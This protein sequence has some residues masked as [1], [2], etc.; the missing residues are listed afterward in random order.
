MS[1]MTAGWLE[2]WL[3][4]YLA[5]QRGV[6]PEMIDVRERFSRHGLDS[7]GATKLLVDLGAALGRA[8]S[9]TLIWEHPTIEALARSLI[10]GAGAQ[11]AP[12]PARAVR[13][14]AREPV[15]IV[16]L[17]C[18][19][20]KA[21]SA[22]AFW[23]LL[24]DGVDAITE[25][26]PD[27]WDIDALYDADPGAPGKMS[28]RWGGFLD[29]VDRFD[30]GFFGIS[31]REAIQQDP[32]QR[33]M[34]ELSWEALEDA[35]LSP[36]GLMGSRTGVFFGAMWSDYAKVPGGRLDAIVQHTATGQDL[37]IIPAR[38][39]YTLGLEGPSVEVST[40]CSS[41]LVAVHLACQS[42]QSG[43]SSLA[44][45]GGVNLI[46]SP[47][48]TIAMSKFGA[49]SPDGRSRAFDAAANGYVRGEGGGVVV[50]KPLSLALADG[51]PIY[52][53]IRGSAVNND[54]FSN[55]LTAPNPRAQEAVLR[56]AW[57]QAGVA[58]GQGHYVEAHGTG[59]SLGDPIEAK[60]LG[61]VFGVGRPAE[62]PLRLGS[63][64]TNIGH[65]EAAAGVAGLIKA[66]LAIKH[67][68]IPPSLHFQEPNPH[69]P[70]E[71]LRLQVQRSA[72]A[73]PDEER[74]AL[75]GVSAFGFGGTNCH[76]VLEG[77]RSSPVQL[78][79]LSADS[80]DELRAL[81]EEHRVLST[82]PG[83]RA[84]LLELCSTAAARLSHRDHRLAMTVRSHDDVGAH[85]ESF[86]RGRVRLG[87]SFSHAGDLRAKLVFVF[88]G[89][90]SQW[91][92]MGR[93]LLQEEPAFRVELER[94]E[95]AM[96]PYVGW[97]LL[98]ELTLGGVRQPEETDVTQPL[99]VA[100]QI[101]LAAL[102]RSWGIEPDAVIGQ[103]IGEVAAAC[104]SGALDLRDTAR[105]I[106]LRS[107]LLRRLPGGLGG[108]AVV[109]LAPEEAQRALEG[110]EDRLSV[111]IRNSPTSTVLS[112]DRA[113]LEEVVAALQARGVIC[114]DV[115]I[116]YASHSPQMDALVPDLLRAL[117]GIRPQPGTVPFYSTVTGALLGGAELDAAYWCRNEREP[118]LFSGTLSRLIEE[119]HDVF[120]DIGPHPILARAVRQNL[121]HAG[122]RGAVLASLRRDEDGRA[123]LL[124]SLGALFARGRPVRWHRLYPLGPTRQASA[125]VP[126]E[127]LTLSAQGP[128]AL[129][130]AARAMS[131]WLSGRPDIPLGDLCYTANARRD[132]HAH[133]L[134][135]VG[136]SREEI[137]ASLD[138]FARGEARAGT[139]PGEARRG[140][141]PGVV[142]VFSGQ[143]SQWAGM[144]RGLLAAEPVFR[145]A[146][147][148]CEP[149]VRR[150]GG[151]SLLDELA[152]PE[153]TSRLDQTAVAQPALF[154]VQVALS[155]LWAAWGVRPD[156]VIGHSVGEVAAAT[157]AGALGL[158]E[159]ARLVC[160]RGLVMQRATGLGKMASVALSA[161]AAERALTG[162]EDRLCVAAMNDPGSVVLSG[163][164]AA[165]AEVLERLER[166]AVR[167]RWLP[168]HY[169]FHSPQMAPF[170]GEL[171]DALG[172][173]H[174]RPAGCAMYST[175]SGAAITG[176]A[177]DA[178]YW[179]R[180]LR[181]PVRFAQAV[182]AAIGEGHR[183]F[184]EIGPHPVLSGH[185]E[186]CLDGREEPG[187]V[188]HSL[189]REREERRA[190]LEGLGALHAG[191]YPVAWE[192]VYP[193]GGRCVPL[194]AYPWQRQRYWVE[195]AAPGPVGT[196]DPPAGLYQLAWQEQA[197]PAADAKGPSGTWLVLT[198][199]SA[200]GEA[201][202]AGLRSAGARCVRV[203]RG[204]A[205]ERRA[206]D[207][208]AV[209]PGSAQ[210]FGP[211][212][213]AVD[214]EGPPLQGVVSLWGAETSVEAGST[215]ADAV[216]ALTVAGLH[217]VQALA[218]RGVPLPARLWWVTEGAQAVRPGEAV[219]AEQAP[220]WG[221]GRVV[222]QEHP[223]LGGSLVDLE[224][225]AADGAQAL[226]RELTRAEAEDETQVAWRSGKRHVARLVKAPAAREA[227]SPQP[228]AAQGSVL[229]TGGLGALGLRVARWLREEHHVEH[230]V[231][232]GR[233]APEGERLSAVEALRAAGARVTVAQADVADASQLRALLAALPAELPLRGVV[234]AA[235]VLSDGVLGQQD[236]ARFTSVLSPKVR[237]A[238]NLHAETRGLPL[239]F[240]VLFSS[241]AS[242][243]GSAGQSNYA[244]GNAFLDALA[245]ARR[246]EGLPA[247]SLS[248]SPWSG[249]GMAEELSSSQRA[250]LR[251]GVVRAL[252]PAEGLALLGQAL[253]RPEAQLGVLALELRAL[254]RTPAGGVAPVWRALV[255]P[256]PAGAQAD[257]ASAPGRALA[258]W[259]ARLGALA[260]AARVAEVE[261]AVRAEVARVLALGSPGDV[262]VDRPLKDL[263]FDSLMSVE[264]RN[265]LS[266][267]MGRPLPATLVFDHPTVGALSRY[268]L[269]RVLPPP[270]AAARALP[271]APTPAM[272][273]E[274]IAIVGIGCRFPGGVR[275]LD[276][277]WRLLDQG[278]DAIGEV[279]A[280]RWS[281]D[282]YY[283]PDPE[284]PGKMTTRW[285]GF[286]PGVDQFEPGFF[287]ISPREAASLDPQQR[288][289][290]EVSWEALEQAGQTPERLL[291]SDTGVYMGVCSNDYRAMVQARPA[292]MDAY[293]FLGTLPSTGVS[294][295]SYWLGL[296]GPNMP[297]DTACSSSLVAVHLACQALRAGECSLALAG[298]VSLILTPDTTLCLSG[299]RAMSPTGRCHT[300]SADADG[301]VRSEGCGV[302]VLKRLSDAARD[303]DPILA[304][305]RG[306]A[307][308]QD[309]RSNGLTAPNGPS[310]EAVI[311]RALEQAAVAPAAVGYVEAHGTGTPLGDPI[312]VQALGAVLGEGRAPSRPVVIG[313]VKTNLG[314]TEGAA[315][316]A[317]LIKAV[318]S[319]QRG[320]I[321]RSLHFTAPNP[322]VSWAELPVKV[323][324]EAVP[325]PAGGPPRIAGVSAF[326]ISGTNAHVVL[327]EAPPRAAP[328]PAGA[329][330][331]LLLPL[332]ARTPAALS[333]QAQAY[334]RLLAEAPSEASE[335]LLDIV[336]TASVR[337]SHHEHR[338]AVVGS[339]REEL[340]AALEAFARG[341][342]RAG[343]AQGQAR[344]GPR[345]KVVFVY[346]GQGS[347]WVGMGRGLIEGEPV[348][349]AEIEACDRAIGREAGWSL[350]EALH[351][352]AGHAK[353]DPID[354][355]QPALFAMAVALS[356]LWRSWGV[357]PDAVVGHSM[358]EIAAAHVAGALTLE[359]AVRIICRRSR[360]LREVSGQGAMA[361]VE[362]SLE[363]AE[364]ALSGH[365][366]RLSVAVSNSPRSTVL[367]GDP[368]ALEEVLAR[369]AGQGVFC[370]RV[371]VDVASHS[372]QMDPLRPALLRALEGLAPG[373]V[374][375]PLYS[376]VTGAGIEGAELGAA[377]WAQNLRAPV[378]FSL[379]I[380]RLLEQGHALFVEMS[381]HPIL[382]P[383]IEEGLRHGEREGAALP[384]LRREQEERRVLL[385][386]MGALYARG[387]AVAFERLVPPGGRCVPLPTYPWQRERHW[388]EGEAEARVSPGRPRTA[389]DGDPGHPLL[390]ASFT[391]STQ[392]GARFWEQALSLGALPYLADHRVRG[393]A[394]LPGAAYV[395]MCLAAAVEAHGAGAHA[396]EE[397][398]FERMLALPPDG[399]PI[400]QVALT[401]EEPGRASLQVS[402]REEPGGTWTR[403]ATG[404]LRVGGR[405]AE[406]A[407][408]HEAPAA[409]RE[410]CSRSV[411]SAEHYQR[412]RERGLDYGACFQGVQELWIGPGEVLGRVRLP[413][414][415]SAEALAYQLHPALLDA[416]FQV[417]GGSLPAGAGTPDR[418]GTY[419][420]AGLERARVH[421]RPGQEVWVHARLRAPE[422]EGPKALTGDLRLVGEE[423]ELLAEAHGLRLQQLSPGPLAAQ[424]PQ[425]ARMY[426]LAWRQREL[427]PEAP[428]P[429]GASSPGAFLLLTDRGET[430][431][432]LAA[433]LEERG[434][435]CVRVLPG[436]RY[437]C[438]APGLYE[439]DP[440][441][442]KAFRAL[443]RDAF[444]SARPCRGV[445]H[446]WSLDA[447]A[448]AET[449][450]ESLEAD[451]RLGT[452][453]A[454][455]LAQALVQAGWR[456]AP[457]LLLA[458]RGAQA[459]GAEAAP[460]AVAQAPAWGLGR[461]LAMEHPELGC[462]RVDLSPTRGTGE[463]AALLRELLSRDGEDQIAL[464]AEGR[465]VARLSRS[466]LGVGSAL[467]VGLR[468]EGSYLIT[469]GL[470][471]LGLVAA[472]WMVRQGA[473]HL[474]LVGRSGA[475]EAALAAIRELEEAGAEVL[476]VPADV[477]RRTEVERV[478][479]EIDQRLPPLRGIVHAAGILDDR[480][481]LELSAERFASVRAPKVEGAWNL[482]ALTL[483]RP[484]D[485]FVLY[486]SS[487]SL[488]GSPGQGN[489]AAANAF[490]DALAHERRRL[491]LAGLSI[492]WGPFAEVGLAAA[493]QNRGER[494]S[495]RGMGSLTPALGVEVLGRLL[496]GEQTQVGVLDLDLRQW[497]EFYPSVAGAPLWSEL[498]REG[499]R[500]RPTAREASRLREA[501]AQAAPGARPAL[502]EAHIGEELGRVLRLPASRIDRLSA[503]SS[504]GVDSL[505]SLELRNRLESSLG[506]KLSATLLF[507][508]PNLSS[509]AEHLLGAMAL[510]VEP[511]PGRGP[512][513]RR[514]D[515]ASRDRPERAVA[516]PI[517]II[518]MGCR[519]PGGA[520]TPEAFW[521]LL[522]GGL[523]AVTEV[524]AD[525][526]SLPAAEDGEGVSP[527][528]RAVRW[529]AFLEGVDQFDPQFFGISPREAILLDP[530]QRL[531]L[532]VTWEALEH[533][534]QV[535]ERLAG[536]RAGVFVGM[537]T[538]DYA[539]LCA[540]ADPDAEDV[541]EMTGN[542]HCFPPGRLSYVLGLT[543]P[544]LTVDTACSSSLVA[545]HLACQSLRSGESSLA[546]VAGVNLMLSPSLTEMLSMSGALSP[547]GRCKAF[548]AQANG[549]VRG[550][551]CGVVVLKRLSD[552]LSDGDRVLSLIRGSAVNQDGRS[553]GLTAP[554]VLSQQAMLRQA[555]E[556][557]QVSAED[558]GYIETHGTGTSLGD[559]IEFEA[560]K[561]VLG[562]PRR[563]GSPCV[564]GA[565]KTNVGHLE[566]AAGVAGLIKAVLALEHEA[567]PTNLHWRTLNPRITLDGTPFVIPTATLS[568]KAKGKA[569]YAGVSSFGLSG[570]NAHVMLEAARESAASAA[571]VPAGEPSTLLFPLS[572][573]TPEALSALAQ[574][575]LRFLAEAPA[576][577]P[578]AL[579]E[580]AY[581]AS[582]RRSHHAHRFAA[583][584][585]SREELSASLEAFVRGEARADAAHGGGKPGAR[586]KVVFVFPGQGS[587]WLGMGRA[588]LDEEPAFREAIEACDQAIGREAGFS[589][590][591]ELRADEGQSQMGRIDVL[592]PL[593][594]AVEVALAAAWRA[595][596][597]E[598]DAVVGHSMGEV[599]AAYVVGALSLED[600]ARII[601]RRSRL[602]RSVSGQGAM[603][604]VELSMDQAA[605]A[606]R[607]YEDRLSVAASN[608]SRSTVLSGDPV[609]LELVLASLELE[610]VFC[611][612]V[613]VDV[614]SHSPQ[615]DPL[616][617]ELL[618]GLGDL[619]PRAA[620]RPMRSTVTGELVRG[621][622]LGAEYWVHNLR[623][624]VR[625]S[626]VTQR[627][628]DDGHAL[629][630][631]MSPHPILLPAIEESLRDKNQQGAAV[632]SLRRNAEERRSLLESLA[633][634]YAAGLSVD[635]SR[636]YPEGGR[637][638]SLP[639]YPWQRERYWVEGS[640]AA[641]GSLRGARTRSAGRARGL[642]AAPAARDELS[643][644]VYAIEWHPTEAPPEPTSPAPTSPL[645]AWLVLS[646]RG[647]TGAALQ[648]LLRARGEACVRVV[649]GERYRRLEPEL[650]QIDPSSS[651]DYRTLLREVFGEEGLCAG[652]VHLF[653]LDSPPV[654]ATT[655]EAL[656]ADLLR[657][658]VSAASVVK[659]VV[660][661]GWRDAPRLWLITRGAQAVGG[662]AVSVS[663][664]PLWGLGRTIALEHPELECTRIDL[665]PAPDAPDAADDAARLLRE[666]GA[667]GREDQ[668]ALRDHG[669]HVA[670]L[671]RSG[672]EAG[673]VT[674]A[675]R[676]DASYLITGGLG[677]LGLSVARWMVEQGARHVALAGRRGPSAEAREAIQ[678]M[679]AAGAQ[680]VALQA[681]VSRTEEVAALLS[682][683]EERLPPLR[684]IVHAAAVLDDHTLLELSEEHWRKVFAP[685][686]RG[687]WNL[688][689]LTLGKP[690]DFFV[691]YSSA[692]SL[693]GS[694]GQGNYSA[695]SA[696]LDALAH[697]REGLGLPAISV[698][699]GAF[700]EVGLAAA[701]D[702]RGKRLSY[703]GVGSLTPAEGL[704]SLARLLGRPRA[705][706]GVVRF[707]VRQWIEFYPRASGAPFF[708]ELQKEAGKEPRGAAE[709]QRVRGAL[710]RAVPAER[711]GV[712][713]EHLRTVLGQVLRLDPSRIDRGASFTSL[714]MDSLMSLELRN[715]L[716]GSLGLKLSATLL[717]TYPNNASLAENL[718]GLLDPA[719]A[720]RPAGD[721]GA[722]PGGPGD[723]AELAAELG[724]IERLTEQETDA[725]LEAE[726]AALEDYV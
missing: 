219:A 695:A 463:A 237:G 616:R 668:I 207:L 145:A 160:R 655:P 529:G 579:R 458:T 213:A 195:A 314:H 464:R 38:I 585:R 344:P 258:S 549:F 485:F 628:I 449:T 235:G 105:I 515:E 578:G 637:V 410:R 135:S 90:G 629:F 325:W 442:P 433:L 718:L 292:A 391:V 13:R 273:T 614:A 558:V 196:P 601:C 545:V 35:G 591:E 234:H 184:L 12:T 580:I 723:A 693:F 98:E 406:A 106:C 294:R 596:G 267:R 612:R 432:A 393:E 454:L 672:L 671:V 648:A 159:A 417:L 380:Q 327:E 65:L 61:A 91:L 73:W 239:D 113:A 331:P 299:M 58:P 300:F 716:E 284:A 701:E 361:L 617:E 186:R 575:Y 115:R 412:M 687:A 659:A 198:D 714:G 323:A 397:V 236:A 664:A 122:R 231:L 721:R 9:P 295:L 426:A 547:D 502:L 404:S 95:Q 699:W 205:P 345:P 177:L 71:D 582:V 523:D 414:A 117:E 436:E 642:D 147:E 56:E 339:S 296:K 100:I 677:G 711:L 281:P 520:S 595:W 334:G 182:D 613:K 169:A 77:A 532:E 148:A 165:L 621:D 447:T 289:L 23:R 530:Q 686:A 136:R 431:A 501:L 475:S 247:Q 411:P 358:G 500:A 37:S 143:G 302:V 21:P 87:A 663:Q 282:A 3:V 309:G 249:G 53:V 335:S 636:L 527:R 606:L 619:A 598:P 242:L 683:L 510:S 670:R 647:G 592:Q 211:A 372:P 589:V 434:E 560:L 162:Y 474:V 552:A 698:Q 603:A 639:A 55:G 453:S 566:A 161:E 233:R 534:G 264:L 594:F 522:E 386:S 624:P 625:F 152:A 51:D 204:E 618:S 445:V 640:A 118:V 30:P 675:L 657:G 496:S 726:M 338:L 724:R 330:L 78:L 559:P 301:Y 179:G 33:L 313:S 581:T 491:G 544:S 717:F 203:A 25:V 138:A 540:A 62:R 64:K 72:E 183:S 531:L 385:E 83:P 291:G 210:A 269:D 709:A 370:R 440:A 451:H 305:I 497:L 166:Q 209:A 188:V 420:P 96:R 428:A 112:G 401:E 200:S 418:E 394:V 103:S 254:R 4:S 154:A 194:P 506:L 646:D 395:E 66:A 691:M 600:A 665:S 519:F 682:T 468:A 308:N 550:E 593:L 482:H 408:S 17:S 416:C 332:S 29:Q 76:V 720:A 494:L 355:V 508:Y 241:V 134:A 641:P 149:L 610:K 387:H 667:T 288:L 54:G 224:P 446:L 645:G 86:L 437:A 337:R 632:G 45:A 462:T 710:E 651:E 139:T 470:G 69:I 34:M 480:T 304:V 487:A 690:L 57:E 400:V 493:Q 10:E 399:A 518:G 725:A 689:A 89:Q 555:L 705:E 226:W 126:A 253:S 405:A 425:A 471:G 42:L 444:G 28:T 1:S 574:A 75:A 278:V 174:A 153:A 607:G 457:R 285:G 312:E 175:V 92:G 473:R 505:M 18:R 129:R 20:P 48:S 429:R 306:S 252:S 456:D 542:G 329:E 415:A 88:G 587:Q 715:R 535:P 110:R 702:I 565:V 99:I 172:A 630:V 60:A 130:D 340:G 326:G 7:L 303:G 389:R 167:C 392:P 381:P 430:G 245:Q 212:L 248:F 707:D 443:L 125:E 217:L 620:A 265:A 644:C 336:H 104:V 511:E 108:M 604:L 546:L 246:A 376:T 413:E 524:P 481:V 270:D 423:G 652:V 81:A 158:E 320:C 564:L 556:S 315:G 189:R 307:V 427:V 649:A 22:A 232:V 712:L 590:L 374:T 609:A 553:T 180:N 516:E 97:S 448:A 164:A 452:L 133:R 255:E 602:L 692:A 173:L 626:Q 50:L 218:A 586:P 638:V 678:A 319:L 49:M 706:V 611:R 409:I 84:P 277:F 197:V 250:R 368:G 525:R 403:H 328:P 719:P 342:P 317:G 26:P 283:D 176:E 421:R 509:L 24:C 569:R 46:L 382:T 192:G 584:A 297:V 121:T 279:P 537:S 495:Y 220:L 700:S 8:L 120:L 350:L 274:P 467:D 479:A 577:D 455:F 459:V 466:D 124:D 484:L 191:G 206:E 708:S 541:Y 673:V 666:L 528:A 111:A 68:V 536:S 572:A 316:V 483:D 627:L 151:F 36:R 364:A 378:L 318:L 435:A 660:R 128:E 263:G 384:S 70:F 31:P 202:V 119:G 703:R 32:Q 407:A 238:W 286:L 259:S 396:I 2:A 476:V 373:A 127:L 223:E 225:G 513:P 251:H 52:C 722:P 653:S 377:Y 441:D 597:L 41:S 492:N 222:M 114:R 422:G 341:E 181:A 93:D 276:S 16:G 262:A 643:E 146:I 356:A 551:G 684:G 168:V 605:D 171:V 539:T 63:V 142:F 488:L 59:T 150:Y 562:E 74:Q 44:L 229:I 365:Q 681:D 461:T 333:A 227:A 346:P 533:A 256:R 512:P 469:G 19:F 116:G 82:A 498:L 80:A 583:V 266:A 360:L 157:V 170:V 674:P 658:S 11:R 517:A 228:R 567:I 439:V 477:S 243:L 261:A 608:G 554:N 521:R 633:A 503:F 287:E 465:Y 208:F 573:R 576:V 137:G 6:A 478:L 123:V 352:D 623:Q 141:R 504:L 271:P 132:H 185:V 280:E 507:T 310:Q 178:A 704:L 656:D 85:V 190:L 257:D 343:I 650:V 622:E 390:G 144:G 694:P 419:V 499:S 230:L 187:Q 240:F 193:L 375:V 688:H 680:V 348:F 5:E 571:S 635:W 359:D 713:E 543:G 47:E 293:S 357:E 353:L 156:A 40:A 696:F 221:L 201:V 366:D 351:A 371:K 131:S 155:A 634:L 669:R 557:A 424:G 697:H 163:E 290:L 450:L 570:T 260:P 214:A 15:A 514:G 402:S 109:E 398:A 661:Q 526:W 486:S 388:I 561:A 27:R 107:Q 94:F 79:A 298:G 67:R 631:E 676:G 215:P 588:L 438:L 39:S 654:G 685:K 362:L 354:V 324:A 363:Q 216:E 367:S 43:E 369:L 383:A 662:G 347:Q 615:M 275:D 490:L 14:A 199:G 538:N 101:A 599:A 460:V 489:Y 102:W 349:R 321:P 563:D 268:L 379:V 472:R 244:A 140:R 322:H 311:R 272:R 568:W 679:E 548:D